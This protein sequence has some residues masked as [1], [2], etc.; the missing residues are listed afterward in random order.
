MI[1]GA[2]LMLLV[3]LTYAPGAP[4]EALLCKNVRDPEYTALKTVCVTSQQ[5]VPPNADCRFIDCH[6]GDRCYQ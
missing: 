3:F 1:F 2:L 4:M 5:T 6:Y